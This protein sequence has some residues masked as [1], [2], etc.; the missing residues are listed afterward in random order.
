MK[1][2][3]INIK[4]NLIKLKKDSKIY[5]WTD[6]NDFTVLKIKIIS[7]SLKI[8][9]NIYTILN[10]N[11]LN[12]LNQEMKQYIAEI[13]NIYINDENIF[14]QFKEKNQNFFIELSTLTQQKIFKNSNSEKIKKNMNVQYNFLQQNEFKITF[15][16]KKEKLIIN[17][18]ILNYLFEK[19]K[20]KL[21]S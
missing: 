2:N 9:S 1:F 13:E 18:I 4:K 11:K 14:Q 17:Q 3:W 15:F 8:I 6:I 12:I 7:K 16:N 20:F 10:Y 19:K 5:S 21:Y